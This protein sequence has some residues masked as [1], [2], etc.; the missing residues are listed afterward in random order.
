MTL[1]E[2]QVLPKQE[3]KNF[4]LLNDDQKK[5][6][7]EIMNFLKSPDDTYFLLQGGA[8]TGKTFLLQAVLEEFKGRIVFTAPTNKATK[9]I[10]DTITTDD[11]RPECRTIYA[12]LGLRLEANGEIK[13]LTVPEDPLDLSHYR[14]IVVDEGSMVNKLLMS[15]IR[16]TVKEFDLKVIFM[17]DFAQIPPVGE[18]QS[19][20]KEV[21]KGALLTKVMRYDNQILNLALRLRAV[22]DHPAPSIKLE[23][24]NAEG[25]GIWMEGM[26]DFERKILESAEQGH[27]TIPNHT[28]AI[29]WRNVTVDQLNKLIR[30]R[31]FDKP[32]QP[33]LVGDRIIMLEPG[34]NLD[35]DPQHSTDDEG[36]VTAVA[37]SWHPFYAEM[38]I[39]QVNVTLDDNR[40]ISLCLLH[41]DSE[42]AHAAR[43][44]RMAAEARENRK[45]W[46]KF[47]DFKDAFHKARHAYAITAHRSQGSTYECVFVNWR[48]ILLNQNRQEAYRCLYVAC[49]RPKKRLILG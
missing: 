11:Y 21:D 5:A 1:P 3:K 41:R 14:V 18:M 43:V 34:K 9:V 33:W 31:I 45:L 27:F 24:D 22:V 7:S 44:A 8:G 13:E 16:R 30:D 49:T 23:T 32:T 46:G 48:D 40:T 37:E 39:W 20:V 47:W 2:L 26:R 4:S 42:H 17:A 36:T 29:A 10:R 19:A 35:G 38:K 28:K 6:F 25:E 12:L 15:H